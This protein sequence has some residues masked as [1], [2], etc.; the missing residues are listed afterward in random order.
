M[1]HCALASCSAVAD[2]SLPRVHLGLDLWCVRSL[3]S[4][5]VSCATC[6]SDNPTARLFCF[7]PSQGGPDELGRNAEDRRRNRADA[8]RGSE[9]QKRRRRGT[10]F[11]KTRSAWPQ[12]S[13][14]YCP[15][16]ALSM[17]TKVK[18]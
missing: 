3:A 16:D 14:V 18:D 7:G 1:F 4:H 6:Y 17:R 10:S 13:N 9:Q 11:L 15:F 8:S 2:V 12:R 5:M